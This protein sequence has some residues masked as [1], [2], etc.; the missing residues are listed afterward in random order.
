MKMVT[1]ASSVMSSV[2]CSFQG[3]ITLSS[4][5]QNV[6]Q[7][8]V[9]EYIES[10]HPVGSKTLANRYLV[11]VSSATIRNELMWLEERG[12]IISPHISAGRVPTNVGYRSFVNSL[13]LHPDILLMQRRFANR[14]SLQDILKAAPARGLVTEGPIEQ[15]LL[16]TET[17]MFLSVYVGCLAVSWMPSSSPAVSHRGL[18]TL[19]TQPEFRE[20]TAAL[21]LIQLL[22]NHG[23]LVSTL[24]EVHDIPGLHIR[25][26]TEHAD[27]QLYAFSMVASRIVLDGVAGVVALFGPTRMDYR[28]A[29]SALSAIITDWEKHE[30]R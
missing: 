20:T 17:L 22:E 7:A 27:S 26:G 30:Q 6:L 23:D 9:N 12:Y 4:R 28:K 25:I 29:I 15:Q 16:I 13:L 14:Q 2:G 24:R 1:L 19:M 18:A 21:P 5:R 11:N 3:D 8:L 10:A